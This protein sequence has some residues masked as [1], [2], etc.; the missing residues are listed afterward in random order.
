M[1]NLFVIF[2]SFQTDH[3]TAHSQC[4]FGVTNSNCTNNV[5]V[6]NSGFH[7]DFA[8]SNTTCHIRRIFDQTCDLDTDCSDAVAHS[9]C[10]VNNTCVCDVGYYASA[11]L[12]TCVATFVGDPCREDDDCH[13]FI[14]NAHCND[15]TG[16]CE[17]DSSF[18]SR[19]DDTCEARVVGDSCAV[20]SDC[21]N[22]DGM[23]N[24]TGTV[25]SCETGIFFYFS[26]KKYLKYSGELPN[27]L[28][29]T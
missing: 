14:S 15:V 26:A 25:C 6:C 3:C 21:E 9:N 19:D 20:T 18:V 13:V 10:N 27:F 29:L 1:I 24:C 7:H 16:N 5:C 17:C 23:Y 2:I 11:D 12:D 22:I 4:S 8:S 28:L